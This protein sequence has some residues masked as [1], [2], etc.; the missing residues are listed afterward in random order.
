VATINLPSGLVSADVQGEYPPEGDGSIG[1]KVQASE[2]MFG[3][4]EQNSKIG[5]N[6]HDD[7]NIDLI[8][9][10]HFGRQC[11]ARRAVSRQFAAWVATARNIDKSLRKR[12]SAL[13]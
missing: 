12:P 11:A 9:V 10:Q 1:F 3:A 13:Q 2:T 8:V 4:A 7:H 6:A 5:I